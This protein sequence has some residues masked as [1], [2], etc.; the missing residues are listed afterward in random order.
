[1]CVGGGLAPAGLLAA[2]W[3]R[4]SAPMPLLSQPFARTPQL[5]LRSRSF[6]ASA[7]LLAMSACGAPER[8]VS[9]LLITLDTTRADRI[10]CYGRADAGTPAIDRLA[11]RGA[12]F[13][14]ILA[15]VPI[16]LPSHTSLMTG[17][18]PPYHGVRD[19]GLY[20]VAPELHTLAEEFQASGRRT[21]AFVSAFP[22]DSLFGLDAGFEVFD[23]NL[24]LDRAGRS[25]LMMERAGSRTATNAA[26][27]LSHLSTSESFFT[28][29]H[30]FDPH[31]PYEAP[32]EYR[33]QFPS[34]P[35]QAE[36][37]S[38]DSVV[39]SLLKALR[40]SGRLDDTIVV[41]T[42]DHGE[43]LG[44]HG[45]ETHALLLYDSTLHVPLVI[46]GPGVPK[47]R[48]PTAASLIDVAPTIAELAGLADDFQAN[49]ARSLISTI[50]GVEA[51]KEHLEPPREVYFES[52]YPRDHNGWSELVG[53]EFGDWKYVQAP[54]A[55][56]DEDA[57]AGHEL[58]SISADP[59]ERDNLAGTQNEQR[60]ALATRLR[61]LRERLP[62]AESFDSSRTLE[63]DEMA[64]LEA[65]GYT[66]SSVYV[67]A[68]APIAHAR[69]PRQAVAAV[70]AMEEMRSFLGRGEFG[71]AS[72]AQG[73]V[74]AADP[75]GVL[76]FESEGILAQALGAMNGPGAHEE[77]ERALLAFESASAILPG[78]RGLHQKQAEVLL[79]LGE[80]RS[81]LVA[82][83]KALSLAPASSKLLAIEAELKRRIGEAIH[84]HRVRGE[85][86]SAIDLQR[87]LDGE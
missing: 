26:L 51:Q 49:S 31:Y 19:N 29:V 54:L 20:T 5:R 23:D 21:A 13:E 14:R 6:L 58:Y 87:V 86:K 41:L 18:Y 74:A 80:Y 82:C 71:A 22:L 27:W 44:D 24:A 38:T 83:R 35:Y 1:M 72:A 55:L 30:L 17:S 33:A 7:L 9:V 37:A 42:A 79:L 11:A 28:W 81:G 61:Q 76:S 56:D 40:D 57:E 15:P 39:A 2:V 68:S 25:G 73:K 47:A 36:I 67:G 45:E 16:T 53:L 52:L 43:S 12:L 8:P 78:R 64:A 63:G 75:G 77:L 65:L 66:D 62:A 50:R 3:G 48:V 34:D 46:A 59:F 10:G 85:E 32:A 70:T 69:D 84:K 60:E 4:I